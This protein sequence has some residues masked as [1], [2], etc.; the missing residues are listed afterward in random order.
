MGF[1]LMKLVSAF[2]SFE[3]VFE[4]ERL[5]GGVRRRRSRRLRGGVGGGGCGGG[6]IDHGDVD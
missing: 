4:T 6:G 1:V 3:E 5:G 2:G